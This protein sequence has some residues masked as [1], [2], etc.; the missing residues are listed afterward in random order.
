MDVQYILRFYFLQCGRPLP[1]NLPYMAALE[2]GYI[3]Q[4]IIGHCRGPSTFLDIS[5]MPDLH[6][7]SGLPHPAEKGIVQLFILYPR[8]RTVSGIDDRVRRQGKDLLPGG[9][10]ELI[11]ITAG[12]I[13]S[14]DGT[15][16]NKI[17]GKNRPG[18]RKIKRKAPW[19]VSR[20]GQ[21]LTGVSS[22]LVFSGKK[23]LVLKL[24]GKRE[25]HKP[26]SA[27]FRIQ[28]VIILGRGQDF[29]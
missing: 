26:A 23:I 13:G 2:C 28:Q 16:K 25:P 24:R 15:E 20:G 5:I 10:Y 11:L 6:E 29:N 12:E 19:T 21:D 4:E 14:P 7:K 8:L 1:G 9:V 17:P 18:L 3:F 22:E 27:H